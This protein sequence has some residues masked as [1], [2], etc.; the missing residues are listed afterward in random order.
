MFIILQD[1]CGRLSYAP[2]KW[3]KIDQGGNEV[4]F[5]PRNNQVTL[6][7]DPTSEPVVDGDSKWI[8][9][10]DTIKRRN[11]PSKDAAE[12]EIDRMMQYSTTTDET[13][14]NT[15]IDIDV[16]RRR[17]VPTKAQV[18][19]CVPQFDVSMMPNSPLPSALK[20][21]FVSII[22][23][24]ESP[25]TPKSSLFKQKNP[26]AISSTR[27]SLNDIACLSP[28]FSDVDANDESMEIDV[29]VFGIFF[30]LIIL[31]IF[32]FILEQQLNTD[33]CNSIPRKNIAASQQVPQVQVQNIWYLDA[34]GVNFS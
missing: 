27:T 30:F 10:N 22:S 6:L 14:D 7:N 34:N 23:P 3:I 31:F 13:T 9:I 19:Q 18:K 26:P 5:W 8:T 2:Q 15:D 11:I 32:V 16:I 4:V 29:C 25:N 12:E 17:K 21:Q 24:I 20:N 28:L 1:R 33:L